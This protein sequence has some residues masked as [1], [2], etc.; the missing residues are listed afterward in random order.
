MCENSRLIQTGPSYLMSKEE[1]TFIEEAVKS[2]EEAA[3]F[4]KSIRLVTPKIKTYIKHLKERVQKK[5]KEKQ[6][7]LI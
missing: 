3:R 6:S 7:W 2:Q 1:K 5:G 4:Y